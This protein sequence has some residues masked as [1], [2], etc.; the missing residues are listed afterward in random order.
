MG[1]K[2]H[3]LIAAY[4]I[5]LTALYSIP[6]GLENEWYSFY[7][8]L[9]DHEAVPYV[10]VRE[11]YPPLGFL[12]YMPLYYAFRFS[13][14][15]FSY[16]FRAINGGFLVATVV[17][18]Y[19]I[20]KQISRERRAIWM[21]SC[22]A[23][24]PSV[25]VAN[26]FSN[27]VV[28]LLPGSLA[29]YCMLRGRPLL[30]G[31][32]IGLATLGKGFP[33]LLLIP[34]LISFKSCG[35]RFK[36]LTSAV[37]V[38]SMVSFPFLL[39]NPLTYLST[40]THHG[41]R[42]PW[43]TIWALL[44]GYNSHGGLLHPYFDKFFYHG[45]LL[46]LYSAN[47][48]DHA[49]YTWRFSLLPL[50]LTFGQLAV[51]GL[52]AFIEVKG[53]REIV[54]LC[55]LVYV[56][57]MLFFKGY[58]TQ[59]S[60][61]TQLYVLLATLDAP[62]FFI[63]P[64]EI[65][66]ISQM[67]SWMG[68]PGAPFEAIRELHH[69]LLTS[70]IILRT[71][72][73]GLI[74]SRAFRSGLDLSRVRWLLRGATSA[75]RHFKYKWLSISTCL[76]L[77]AASLAFMQ[78]YG[79]MSSGEMLRLYE[80]S[81]RLYLDSW[82]S[83]ELFGLGGEEQVIV[84]LETGTW[85]EAE[86]LSDSGARPVERGV[87]NPYNLKGS[88]RET[89]LFF[90]AGEGLN[91]LRL[92]MKH[93]RIPF[94]VT[95]GLD[96]DLLVDVAFGGSGLALRLRDQGMD[97]RGSLFRIAYPVRVKVDEEFSLSLRFQV[98]GEKPQRVLLDIFDDTDE[99]LYSFEA[100]EEIFIRGNIHEY[101]RLKGDD[102]SLVALVIELRDGESTEILLEEFSIC[103]VRIPLYVEKE[104]N[105][106]YRVLVERDFRPSSIYIV[107]LILSSVLGGFSL[108]CLRLRSRLLEGL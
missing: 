35:E 87:R 56:G 4:S 90:E 40:F 102:L 103:D 18:L 5:L 44:E 32:L 49:F 30:C 98:L 41:S 66:H 25:I 26:I 48:Y 17:S 37:V 38:L 23:F 73:F 108:L 62:L 64:L 33:F 16:G 21:T 84:R 12:I 104:E 34:A 88:F 101:S 55:G 83:I 8:Y 82:N 96:G 46:E 72:V 57:Y 19:F 91:I 28:A 78:V 22:Y 24:L 105:V 11:G 14:V 99:W 106:H 1:K 86:V 67:V 3:I 70:S 93:P 31:V 6:S 7:A 94:R 69:I 50:F 27:D 9:S 63:I 51:L 47:E 65:S 10:D 45:D 29:V 15:A 42:G 58:S 52:L 36:V 74:L 53:R 81:V 79:Y 2:I 76:A 100:D 107:S 20:L 54:T 75:L 68:F 92:R 13:V 80:G 39:L 61:S 97:N 77:L 71:I 60:V 59:F 95:D 85:L 43:E 89:L